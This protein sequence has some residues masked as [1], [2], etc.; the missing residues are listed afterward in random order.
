MRVALIAV[1]WIL[2]VIGLASIIKLVFPYPS[3]STD[4]VKSPC[5][6]EFSHP[7]TGL[8]AGYVQLAATSDGWV[9]FRE[10]QFQDKDGKP[11]KPE[12]VQ[13]PVWH[14]LTEKNQGVAAAF[15]GN[16][17]TFWNLGDYKA[18]AIFYFR[19]ERQVATV[20][21]LPVGDSSTQVQ[22]KVQFN[23]GTFFEEKHVG[24][25]GWITMSRGRLP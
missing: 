18:D 8:Y 25:S 10:I 4:G 16:P 13:G 6:P 3:S 22:Y 2:G 12:V 17:D 1:V 19:G 20:L 14:T 9:A 21:L 23:G 11:L 5:T 24:L 7:V 15:D